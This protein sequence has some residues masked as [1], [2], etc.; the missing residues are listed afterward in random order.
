MAA[1]PEHLPAA[2]SNLWH[3]AREART[4]LGTNPTVNFTELSIVAFQSQ[5][6]D[7]LLPH[8]VTERILEFHRLN[9]KVMLRVQARC[10]HG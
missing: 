3:S 4:N 9:E 7:Q 2:M 1:D 6:R 8:D 10:H 5:V